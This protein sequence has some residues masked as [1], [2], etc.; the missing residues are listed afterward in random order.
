M[1]ADVLL[2]QCLSDGYQTSFTEHFQNCSD[3]LNCLEPLLFSLSWNGDRRLIAEALPHFSE[4]LT[5]NGFK[6]VMANLGYDSRSFSINLKHID[7]RLM[8]CLFVSQTSGAV[9]LLHADSENIIAYDGHIN[10][11]IEI[12]RSLMQGKVYLFSVADVDNDQF[13]RVKSNWFNGVTKKFRGHIAQIIILTT[14]LN[15]TALATPLF[16][17]ATYDRVIG[18]ESTAMLGNFLIGISLALLAMVGITAIRTRILAYMGA[19]LDDIVGDGI[20]SRIIT[21]PS[22]YTESATVGAQ[23]ARIRD[24]D[25]VRDFFTGPLC[26]L[27]FELPFVLFFIGVIAV[28]SGSLALVPLIMIGVFIIVAFIL[29]QT[30][31]RD[32][33]LNSKYNAK[34][35]SFLLEALNHHKEL[36]LLGAEK[37][38]HERFRDI[39][40]KISLTSF[41][42][43]VMSAVINS[44][45]NV[46]TI[47]AGMAIITLGCSKVIDGNMTIG[48]LIA[49]TMLLWRILTPIKTVFTSY[50][51]FQH[52]SGS[53]RQI[54][55]LMNLEPEWT[56]KISYTSADIFHNKIDFRRIN[57]RYHQDMD[58]SLSNVSFT[59]NAGEMVVISGE[60]GSGKSSL[61]KLLLRLYAPQMG[62]IYLGGK[63]I[64][65][66]DCK[67]LRDT[68]AYVPQVC[69]FFY[70]TIAQNLRL[71]QPLATEAE[72]IEACHL[73]GVYEDIIALP[74][75]LNSRIGDQK[76][77]QLPL[78]LQRR[79]SLAR[80]YLK[81]P[82]LFLLDEPFNGLEQEST[83]QI[84][85][86]LM[87]FKGISTILMVTHIPEYMQRAD[88]LIYLQQGQVRYNDVPDKVL[89]LIL[90]EL[91]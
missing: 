68:V 15:I 90:Q 84:Y 12:P 79:L 69:Q 44:F 67:T 29:K 73:A 11:R 19:K 54:N 2:E 25:T 5:L 7:E 6:K 10:R 33:Y 3:Y 37:I 86:N 46:M 76:K 77:A 36:K 18:A 40:A 60:N 41:R 47:A 88:R 87:S 23:I 56:N 17:M 71:A 57:L 53:I 48:A 16:I 21:L 80:A 35:Q 20:F 78:N 39:S 14:L 81:K 26:T 4:A 85:E 34:R 49:T 31:S 70:G 62:G 72:L 24:L 50:A 82:P 61:L 1:T 75:G 45:A 22:T 28:L 52:I 42:T 30:M 58:P 63:D 89:P 38:W 27:I 65:Q 66:I 74:E 51:H 9:V 8:P 13:N 91:N 43:S 32:I 59:V 55:T 64:R 83:R